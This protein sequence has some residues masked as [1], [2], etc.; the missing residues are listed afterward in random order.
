MG[1]LRELT[2]LVFCM[3]AWTLPDSALGHLPSRDFCGFS[4]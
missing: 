3:N 1:K 2:L 4:H